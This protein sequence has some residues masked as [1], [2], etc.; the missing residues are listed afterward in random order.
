[1]L[2]SNVLYYDV[3]YTQVKP[4]LTRRHTCNEVF[5]REDKQA[6]EPGESRNTGSN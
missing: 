5:L 6:G 4:T 1:M 2:T 3:L